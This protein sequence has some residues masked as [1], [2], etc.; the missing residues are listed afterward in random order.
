MLPSIILRILILRNSS[1]SRQK[2]FA[3]ARSL[4]RTVYMLEQGMSR[5]FQVLY[6]SFLYIYTPNNEAGR[7]KRNILYYCLAVK[8]MVIKV[9]VMFCQ[10]NARGYPHSLLLLL[11]DTYLTYLSRSSFITIRLSKI[12]PV[13]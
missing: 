1:L 13:P 5:T 12:K 11:S 2:C 7:T 9:T 6:C 10:Y 3:C 4:L 8:S